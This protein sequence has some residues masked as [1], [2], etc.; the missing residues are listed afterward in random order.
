MPFVL[1]DW[2]LDLGALGSL[3]RQKYGLNVGQH[4]TLSDGDATEKL[5]QFF[6]VS[7]SQLEMARNNSAFL[8]VAGGVASQLENFCAQVLENSGEVDGCSGSDALGVVAL[9]KQS[10]YSADGKLQSGA[11]RSGLRLCL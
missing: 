5:V 8:V 1:V 9:A 11:R 6:V 7:D 3:F 2:R 10:V 4:T